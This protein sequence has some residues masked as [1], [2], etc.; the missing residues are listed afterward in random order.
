MHFFH[1]QVVAQ[2]HLLLLHPTVSIVCGLARVDGEYCLLA[3]DEIHLDVPVA[4]RLAAFE[5]GLEL[6]ELVQG[7]L[8]RDGGSGL[9]SSVSKFPACNKPQ[10][11]N[12]K[13]ARRDR[14]I[15]D[16]GNAPHPWQLSI[17]PKI[18]ARAN[19]AIA[20]RAKTTMSTTVRWIMLP[21]LN[22]GLVLQ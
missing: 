16:E 8:L 2:R 14:L 7:C 11:P 22:Y 18:S 3:T 12:G 10:E 21:S 5:K 1:P 6:R 13:A 17:T 19:D 15:D 4:L 20:R 9:E